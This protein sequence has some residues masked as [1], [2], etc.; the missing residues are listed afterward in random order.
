M[1]PNLAPSFAVL[2]AADSDFAMPTT[3]KDVQAA[4][5]SFGAIFKKTRGDANIA[6]RAELLAGLALLHTHHRDL[7]PLLAV[8]SSAQQ[9]CLATALALDFP[10]LGADPAW[11]TLVARRIIAKKAPGLTPKKRRPAAAD[12]PEGQIQKPGGVPKRPLRPVPDADRPQKKM[13][14]SAGRARTSVSGDSSAGDSGS[15][16]ELPQPPPAPGRP[17]APGLLM[18]AALGCGPVFDALV[19][20][21]CAHRWVATELL[22][23]SI[24]AAYRS[25]LFCG[26]RWT[27]KAR[28]AYDKMI[29]RQS[30]KH[31]VSSRREDPRNVAFPHRL[32]FAYAADDGLELDAEHL[33][34]VCEGE[35]LSDWAG[36]P[37]RLIGGHTAR[38]EFKAVLDELRTAWEAVSTAARRREHVGAPAL[39]N[40]IDLFVVFLER[41]YARFAVVLPAGRPREEILANVA[42]QLGEL[43]TYFTDFSRV[44]ADGASRL[45][46]AEQARFAGDRYLSLFAPAMRQILDSDCGRSPADAPPG[47][48]GSCGSAG[49]PPPSTRP[50][51]GTL[52]LHSP[53]APP[54]REPAP[55]P[56]PSPPYTT[57][58]LT[59]SAWPHF[60]P[61]PPA[62]ANLGFPTPPP[63]AACPASFGPGP[64]VW[65]GYGGPPGGYPP[66]PG[67][68]PLPDTPPAP[69]SYRAPASVKAEPGPSRTRKEGTGDGS[70]GRL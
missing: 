21:G 46:Y 26:R 18:P 61:Y 40:L 11:P 6:V 51:R 35:R 60:S 34:L 53:A 10:T 25:R 54:A 69:P 12:A 43:R 56:Y 62:Y 5:D 19:S 39:Q 20:A 17:G 31:P 48:G 49:T 55:P 36:V 67:V 65:G 66:A 45:P 7:A 2:L 24:P 41:R 30:S 37:G 1:D 44:L 68:E 9:L 50:V 57:L 4:L 38:S 23:Q 59:P 47:G 3:D 63:P 70:S 33:R 15:D 29:A 28:N 52:Q 42:R 13:K 22:E 58:Q 32:T 27:S 16:V 14:D 8:L 64:F